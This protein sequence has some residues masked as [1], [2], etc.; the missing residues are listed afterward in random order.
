MP[1][2][3]VS[4]TERASA[5]SLDELKSPLN[6]LRSPLNQLK[7]PLNEKLTNVV[8]PVESLCWSEAKIR[9]RAKLIQ[10]VPR[11]SEEN[12]ER[13]LKNNNQIDETIGECEN[14]KSTA[15]RQYN[16][17]TSSRFIGKLL[18]VLAVV[19]NIGD[20]LLQCAPESI[21]IA[22]SAISLLIGVSSF[23]ATNLQSP[24]QLYEIL[25]K[26]MTYSSEPTTSRTAVVYL[27][28]APA[29]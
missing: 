11:P 12:I 13:F 6:E 19:K 4:T 16:H 1:P 21:S 14:L 2:L 8:R 17:S 26:R 28:P 7:G 23:V 24:S 5:F 29:L 27:K 18:K 9:F 15:D 22:W 20:P 10:T 25:T 3:A